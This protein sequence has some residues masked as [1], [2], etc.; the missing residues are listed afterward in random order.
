M[1]DYNKTID[2]EVKADMKQLLSE[3]KKMPGMSAKEA[4]KMVSELSKNYKAAATEA[5]K[6]ANKQKAA[7]DKMHAANKKVEK[8]SKSVRM[9]SREMGAAFG[10]LEDVVG[11]LNPE[12][13]GIASNIG[14]VGQG[15][16]SLSRSMATG[17]MY[18]MLAIGAIAV[19]AA[20][21][22]VLTSAARRAEEKQKHLAEATNE[23]NEKMKVQRGI[24][25]ELV[26]AHRNSTLDLE[27][28]TGQISK[29]DADIIKSRDAAS[30]TLKKQLERQD[31]IIK[32]K[33]DDVALAKKALNAM[34]TLSDEEEKRLQFLMDISKNEKVNIGLKS[35]SVGKMHQ[36]I[37]L[38]DELEFKLSD[39]IV[40]RNRI[41]KA[42]KKNQ[43]TREELLHLQDEYNKESEAQARA[44]EERAK[45]EAKQKAEQAKRDSEAAKAEA[46]AKADAIKE[47]KRLQKITADLQR[48]SDTAKQNA[49]RQSIQNARTQI[50]LIDDR[51]ERLDASVALDKEL[52]NKSIEGLESQQKKNTEV[53]ETEEQIKEAKL[54]NLALDTQIDELKE[55]SHLREMKHSKE[56]Q[57]AL[58]R[59]KK[60]RL[61]LVK[62]IASTA[63]D[64]ANAVSQIIENVS[65]ENKKAAMIAFRVNQ[66]AAIS[67]IIMTT[68]QKVM[69]VAP[70]PFAIAGVSALG[71]LQ[72]GVVATQP[73]P[74][75]HMGGVIDKG[76]DTRNI[77][78]LTG[79]AV[80]DRRTVD[81]L[82]GDSGIAALQR[83]E[84]PTSPQ[85][86]VM[87]PFKHFDRYAKASSKRGGVMKN[88]SNTRASGGY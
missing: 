66:A 51:I 42:S 79:E 63:S 9:Q 21:Y 22:T 16:R 50:S 30:D 5:K 78:V 43:E 2:I 65:G 6:A 61:E 13:A 1:A 62:K 82:G 53:A 54:A 36:M 88:F 48:S 19:L 3:F 67:N 37:A 35:H 23:V 8:S 74:E 40:F 28:F 4:R 12:L 31:E 24:A 52:I 70:N 56:R 84:L 57:E 33:K 69:E 27:V 38:Q 7:M 26:T 76:E 87:N 20:G 29:L 41:E 86:I 68:A 72:A 14:I 83:G 60:L 58:D 49:E 10:S 77:T 34:H 39:E 59:E 73:P 15:F 46:K 45:R 47:E 17:N 25:E 11:G 64:S 85:V 71:A 44:E 75:F 18:V 80:I 81:R 55:K 32:K